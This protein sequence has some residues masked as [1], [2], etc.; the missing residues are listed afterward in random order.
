MTASVVHSPFAVFRGLDT[1]RTLDISNLKLSSPRIPRAPSIKGPL[2]SKEFDIFRQYTTLVVP[3][4]VPIHDHR[5]PWSNYPALALQYK[6]RGQCYLLHAILAHAA[7]VMANAH[8]ENRELLSRAIRF[9][10]MAMEELRM[11]IELGSTDPVSL[12][13][14]II[15]LLFIEVSYLGLYRIPG[16]D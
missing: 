1:C 13:T 10:T 7:F 5:N 11:A 16:S 2:E 14:T 9:H 3:I 4:L 8:G 15:T 12:F 6:E